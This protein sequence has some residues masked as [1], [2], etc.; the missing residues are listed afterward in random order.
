MLTEML[1]YDDE[2]SNTNRKGGPMSLILGASQD[3]AQPDCLPRRLEKLGHQ[4]VLATTVASAVGWLNKAGALPDL[5]L[6]DV[7]LRTFGGREFILSLKNST[8]WK[9][10]P[11]LVQTKSQSSDVFELCEGTLVKPYSFRELTTSVTMLLSSML[12]NRTI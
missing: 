4:V 1:R 9:N 2:E 3:F 12:L 5:V 7:G 6:I 11:I 10:V 8:Y